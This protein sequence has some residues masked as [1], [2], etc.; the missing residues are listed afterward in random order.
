MRPARHLAAVLALCVT[1]TS[2]LP[3]QA[4]A[5]RTAFVALRDST[6]LLTTSADALAL[7]TSQQAVLKTDK[8]N[9]E[10]LVRAGLA[11]LRVGQLGTDR[12][13]LDQAQALFDEAIYRAP[14][15]WP[16]PW[17]GLAL[18][19]LALDST[20]AVVKV[21]MHS[22]A[23]VYY[24]DAALHALGKALEADSTF[25]P[26]AALLGD[27]LLPF[28]ER[29]LN[30]E[31]TRAVRRAASSN[32]AA[33]PWLALGRVYRNLHQADSAVRAFRQFLELGGD[34]ALGL[35]EES[36]SL[37]DLDQVQAA[38]AA[39][40]LGARK[41]DSLARGAYRRDIAW[42]ASPEEL[43]AF[44]AV[45]RDS[46]GE[47]VAAFW[48]KRDAEELR[49]PGERLA[50]HVRRWRYIFEHFQLS[51]RA[52]GTP[53]RGGANC[54]PNSPVVAESPDLQLFSPGVYAAT[55]RGR[56]QVDDRGLI[57]MRHG[58]PTARAAASLE[59]ASA[60]RRESDHRMVPVAT[61]LQT[62]TRPNE[63]WKYVTPHGMLL[64]HFCGSMALGTQAATT[65]VEMLPLTPEMLGARSNLDPRFARLEGLLTGR[66]PSEVASSGAVRNLVREVTAD[67]RRDIQTGLST[68][69]F[70]AVFKQP[71]EPLGQFYA[72]GQADRESSQLLTVFALSGDQL[73]PVPLAQGGVVYPVSLRIVAS[74]A[75][76]RMVRVD[77]TR[78]F[79]AADSL[80]KGQYL[81]GTE[82]M[83]LS[84]GTWNVRLL[85]T[86]PKTDAGGAVGRQQIT[87]P[88]SG[89]LALSDL[90]FGRAG[91]GLEWKS[92]DGVVVLNPLDAY[93]RK[94]SVEVYYELSGATGGREY[95]TDLEL[96][97]VSGDARGEVHLGFTEKATGAVL[98]LRRSVALDPLKGG[99]YRMT[100]TVTEEG[101]GTSVTNERLLNV[102]K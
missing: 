19:D 46:V 57:Y 97:G 70:A 55:A 102:V 73:A 71:L 94:G 39:Y 34:S 42:V 77:T 86:Q 33:L 74:D 24:H 11:Q 83:P 72:V 48:A 6:A 67:G 1:G 27:V 65:L 76:G 54:G 66:S 91:S 92:P 81:F 28:G 98:H 2:L 93:P 47:F 52:E 18:A 53:Q 5:T 26:A 60:I 32:V 45:P 75:Q 43:K 58:E 100:I 15:G 22:G 101:T 35:L 40:L 9:A 89:Q 31:L 95:H 82:N 10:A 99:Q 62:A 17:Y 37:Y 51:A 85:V 8:S 14:D 23:G 78:Y 50:E 29:S 41:V 84:A 56:R 4:P 96:K 61:P 12:G 49:A 13:P 87:V 25:V 44:D 80:G 68:D 7:A 69:E 21:S 88:G 3:A 20:N 38:T 63:S 79:R 59:P 90:V 36:R 16:W 30:G 64:F